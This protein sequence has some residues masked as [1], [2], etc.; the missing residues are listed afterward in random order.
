MDCDLRIGGFTPLTSIDFPG[1]L[2]AVVFCQGCPWRCRYCHNPE[3]IPARGERSIPWQ[4]IRSTLRQRQGLLDG[5]VFSGGEPTAQQGLTEAL[6]EARGMGFKTALHTAGPYPDRLKRLLP[7][8]DWVGLDIKAL[9][10]DYPAI[11]GVPGSGE[12]AWESA[13]R[14]IDA[15]VDYEIRVTAHPA[16]LPP[17]Q[18]EKLIQR[19][20]AMGA[21]KIILQA[22][23]TAATLDP[24]LRALAPASGLHYQSIEQTSAAVGYR[25]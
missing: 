19:L 25:Q 15:D 18:A 11:T 4:E 20:L 14:L 21:E 7:L 12:P 23:Q 16:W 6:R 5:V 3:L 10:E 9:P 22:G 13:R 8:L 24:G 17:A 1:E 2:A